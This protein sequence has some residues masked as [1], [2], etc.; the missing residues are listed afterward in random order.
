MK[1][2]EKLSS[3]KGNGKVV[4]MNLSVNEGQVIK[5]M[6]TGKITQEADLHTGRPTL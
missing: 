6:T 2:S 1:E 3:N 5:E 4:K